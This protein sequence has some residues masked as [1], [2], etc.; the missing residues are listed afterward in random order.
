[1][2]KLSV[3]QMHRWPYMGFH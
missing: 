3:I 2:F 1:M